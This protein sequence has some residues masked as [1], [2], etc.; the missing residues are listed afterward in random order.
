M[1]LRSRIEERLQ[2]IGLTPQAASIR[3]GL[4]KDAVRNVLRGRSKSLST[5]SLAALAE[6]LGVSASWLAGHHGGNGE[7][8]IAGRL[9][10]VK[11][12]VGLGLWR[13]QGTEI[14]PESGLVSMSAE[15]VDH[16]QWLERV[17]GRDMDDRYP[18][19]CLLHVVDAAAIGYA[20]RTGDTVIVSYT[21]EGEEQRLVR[22][23]EVRSYC[24]L[25]VAR[26]TQAAVAGTSPIGAGRIV[27][28][29]LGSYMPEV[30]R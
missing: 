26:S 27:A 28:L 8:S 29:V 30:R 23:V 24:L 7:P 22:Q 21:R 20:P 12:E 1:T 5:K 9:L 2:A 17:V 4:G 14:P 15:Y 13:P 3:A 10:A 25:L 6:T 18:P 11:N 16:D 19:G